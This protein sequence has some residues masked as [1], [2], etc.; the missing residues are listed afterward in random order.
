MNIN[1]TE[2]LIANHIMIKQICKY[3]IQIPTVFEIFYL[4]VKTAIVPRPIQYTNRRTF[5]VFVSRSPFASLAGPPTCTGP[6]P[7]LYSRLE[8]RVVSGLRR[9]IFSDLT[10]KSYV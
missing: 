6:P 5:Q 9:R 3:V 8:K 10:I 7:P 2:H 4:D 1:V